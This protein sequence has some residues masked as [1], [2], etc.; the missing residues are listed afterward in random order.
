MYYFDEKDVEPKEIIPGVFQQVLSGRDENEKLMMVR[1][2]IKAGSIFPSHSHPHEQVGIMVE[3]EADFDIGGE[4]KHIGSG[5]G[6]SISGN[7]E[8]GAVF[9]K[10]S[11]VIDV[12]HPP[13]EDFI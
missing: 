12:F 5:E 10:D 1:Y 6:Y 8:H 13:R 11:I 9:T 4:K 2:V 3:G 7:V